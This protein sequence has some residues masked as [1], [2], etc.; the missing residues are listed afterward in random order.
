MFSH[1]RMSGYGRLGFW[2]WGFWRWGFRRWGFRRWGFGQGLRWGAAL[3]VS[4]AFGLAAPAAWA[5]GAPIEAQSS[6]EQGRLLRLRGDCG[7]AMP[8]FRRAYQIYPKGLGSL[9]NIAECEEASGH[10]AAARSAWMELA[11]SLLSNAEARYAGWTE[12]AAQAT[13]RLTPK[14]GT[15]TVDVHAV[16][17]VEGP[18]AGGAPPS[19]DIEV[20]VN[21]ERV[22]SSLLGT[23]VLRDPGHYVVRAVS[24]AGESMQEEAIDLAPG[25]TRGVD[26]TLRLLPPEPRAASTHAGSSAGRDAAMWTAFGLG[27]A[28]LVGAGIAEAQRQ[29]ALDDRGSTLVACSANS[30]SCTPQNLQSVNDRGNSAAT[31]ENVFFVAGGVGLTTGV[32]LL[33]IGHAGTSAPSGPSGSRAPP[34]QKAALVASPAGLS[35]TGGF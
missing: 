11:R 35:L 14:L 12:D 9:R 34:S 20:S 31:W 30:P 13:A 1:R 10:L 17:A 32:V 3:L 2:R 23:P 29:S 19:P 24:R 33:A 15:L 26:L 4:V 16:S 21:G 18:S 5:D 28:S 7:A 6:F 25:Q 22:S 8:Y 27:A